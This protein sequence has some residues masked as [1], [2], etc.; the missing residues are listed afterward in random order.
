VGG[1]IRIGERVGSGI[2]VTFMNLYSTEDYRI[3][4]TALPRKLHGNAV[5]LAL[6]NLSVF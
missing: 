4:K 5:D 3:K 6:L 2:S 1:G